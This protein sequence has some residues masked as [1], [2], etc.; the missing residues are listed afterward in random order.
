MP[1]FE[2][3]PF[4]AGTGGAPNPHLLTVARKP[5]TTGAPTIPVAV[6]SHRYALTSHQAVGELCLG[7]LV[8]AGVDRR[9]LRYEI[10][11]S[12][13]GEWMNLR[14]YFPDDYTFID[15]QG[16]KLVLR[17]ECFNSIDG[18]SRLAIAF[19]W[20]RQVCANGLIVFKSKFDIKA[21]H[22]R[23]LDLGLIARRVKLS[24]AAVKTDRTRMARR[25]AELVGLE[26]IRHWAD[27]TLAKAWGKRAAA[28]V[29]HICA[30]GHDIDFADPFAPGKA[31][32]KPVRLLARVPGSPERASTKYDVLQA[33]AYVAT[34]R[35]DV[36]ERVVW[37]TGAG[38]LLSSLKSAK[39]G[40]AGK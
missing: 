17:L 13:L 22:D 3:L 35:A 33:L 38:E 18:S 21:R 1:E 2:R 20:Y 40:Q 24:M 12:E 39:S 15:D 29:F 25:Q 32:E 8:G 28:R 26:V 6:V 10:G 36:E 34:N 9:E 27:G 4:I 30:G 11:L 5:V 23:H 19:G 31:S 37:Q 7:A 14:F 16:H